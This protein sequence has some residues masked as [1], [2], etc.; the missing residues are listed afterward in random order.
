MRTALEPA[1]MR[2]NGVVHGALR[3]DLLR[4]PRDPDHGSPIRGAGSGGRSVG[5]WYG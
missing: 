2:I 1:D 4:Y 3:R 5:T